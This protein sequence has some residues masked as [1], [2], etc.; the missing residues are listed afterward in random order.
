MCSMFPFFTGIGVV[1]PETTWNEFAMNF[2]QGNGK[3]DTVI[4]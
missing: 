3:L 1:L 4:I 2:V